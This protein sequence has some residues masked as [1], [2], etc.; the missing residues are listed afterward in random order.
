[1]GKVRVVTDSAADVPPELAQRLDITVLS[2]YVIFGSEIYRDGV[3][4]TPQ[5]FYDKL[6]RSPILPTTSQ[7]PLGLFV[8]TYRNLL[9]ESEGIISIH[10]ASTLSGIFNAARVAAD[11]LSAAP[12]VVIDSQQLSM[13]TGWQVIMAAQAAQEGHTL[14]EVVSLVQGL[15][16][17]ARA[18]VMLDNLEHVRRSGRIS[19]VTALMGTAL[20]VKPL[21][22][23]RN[24]EVA[25]IATVRTREKAL[26][27]LAEIMAAQGAFKELCVAHADAAEAAQKI[28][29]RLSTVH[30]R[31]R[32][33]VCQAG[34]TVTTHLGLG[35]VGICGVLE[36]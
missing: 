7:P 32:L 2:C 35:A 10:I 26:R 25:A 23:I 33:L 14:A 24:G 21:L 36:E 1:M 11:A 34:A 17:R 15:R 9:R 22:Q 20:R 19:R 28:V 5:E 29:E 16:P 13:G 27:R 6:A 31:E 18:A 12:V 3:D 8:E 30:P 4:L